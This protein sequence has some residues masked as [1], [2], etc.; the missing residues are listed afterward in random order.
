MTD[1]T[2]CDHDHEE[3]PVI[4]VLFDGEDEETPC[5]VLGIFDVEGKEYIAIIPQDSEDD[6]LLY[7]FEEN[8]ENE[9]NLTEIESDDE[10]DKVASAFEEDFFD[11]EE[12][13]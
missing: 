2:D 4:K 7:G 12:E 9:I 1:H 8:E 3:I 13:D 6:V 11:P 10:Y 5:D